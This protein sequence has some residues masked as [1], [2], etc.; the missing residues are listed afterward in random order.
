M[1][2]ISPYRSTSKISLVD[3]SPFPNASKVHQKINTQLASLLASIETL[4]ISLPF[5][6]S[7]I[8]LLFHYSDHFS[9]P[10]NYRKIKFGR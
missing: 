6:D 9:T 7:K 10:T 5:C 1:Y 3:F 2:S 8:K 4:L